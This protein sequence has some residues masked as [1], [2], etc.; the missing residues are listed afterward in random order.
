MGNC[1]GRR[2]NNKQ[3]IKTTERFRYQTEKI[4]IAYKNYTDLQFIGNN[5]K[6]VEKKRIEIEIMVY[7]VIHDFINF[8][9]KGLYKE[10]VKMCEKKNSTL[11]MDLGIIFD[12]MKGRLNKNQM[13]NVD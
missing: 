10:C 4:K 5:E 2:S 3:I 6:A 1:H 7:K 8:Q 12:K 13:I 9:K 11:L